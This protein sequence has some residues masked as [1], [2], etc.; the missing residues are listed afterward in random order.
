MHNGRFSRRSRPYSIRIA[1]REPERRRTKVRSEPR[2]GKGTERDRFRRPAG[3]LEKG[4]EGWPGGR[5]KQAAGPSSGLDAGQGS[6]NGVVEFDAGLNNGGPDAMMDSRTATPGARWASGAMG[7][8]G[9]DSNSFAAKASKPGG[10]TG[11]RRGEPPAYRRY[12]PSA[13]ARWAARRSATVPRSAPEGVVQSASPYD[14]ALGLGGFIGVNDRGGAGG[15]QEGEDATV[16]G[17][18]C[19]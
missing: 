15:R 19:R 1:V 3:F 2:G 4:R 14:F 9:L 10:L 12:R 6:H 16:R 17:D 8:P 5:W 18:E 11:R 7:D 13:T